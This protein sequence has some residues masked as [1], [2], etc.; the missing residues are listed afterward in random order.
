MKWF[1]VSALLLLSLSLTLSAQDANKNP[2]KKEPPLLG[3]HWERAT[4]STR[5]VAGNPDM[6]YHGGPI[7]PSVTVKA[8]SGVAVGPV[9]PV[10]KLLVWRNGTS[11]LA[12]P[13]MAAAQAT[14][15]A[16]TNTPTM[17][18]GRLAPQLH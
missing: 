9:I 12:P 8:I 1:I 14:L 17:Q 18:A 11:T 10:T 6:T 4:A 3:P 2:N 5:A 7:L 13:R 15:L 16:A